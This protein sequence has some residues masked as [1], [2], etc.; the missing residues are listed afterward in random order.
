V[1]NP[2]GQGAD[3]EMSCTVR[4]HL[5][6]AKSIELERHENGATARWSTKEGE[7]KRENRELSSEME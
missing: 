1:K 7:R 3:G 6:W 5:V 4:M 2:R